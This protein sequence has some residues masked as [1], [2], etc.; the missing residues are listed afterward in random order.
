MT[1]QLN[2][3][4]RKSLW[5]AVAALV[6]AALPT[7]A[8]AQAPDADAVAAIGEE[9]FIYGFPLVMNYKVFHDSFLD[10]QAKGYKGGLNELH[11]EARVYTSDDRAVQTPNSDTPYSLLGADFRAEPLVICVPQVEAGRYYSVQMVDMYTHNYGYL[12]TRATGNDAGCYLVAGPDW[13]GATPAGIKGVF[14][15]ESPFSLIIFRTQL[16]NAGDIGNV[17]RIQAGYKV[18]TLS[19]F[20]NQP[21]PAA[22]PP[23]QWPPAPQEIF[24][25]GFPVA[26]DFLLNFLPPIGPA[27]GEKALRDRFASIGIGPGKTVRPQDLSPE[28]KAAFG[29][30]M[31][32]ALG[33]INHALDHLG[34]EVNGWR[35]GVAAGSREFYNGDYL[36]RAVGTRG[37]IYGNDSAE[38]TYP[39]AKLDQN[40]HPLD[41]GKHAYLMTFAHGELPP[42][43]AFWSITMYDANSQFLVENPIQRYLI[44]TPMLGDLKRNAD[45]SLSIHVQR[46]SPGKDRESNWL[47][48][49]DGPIFMVMRIYW[50]KTEQPSV[51]P[52]GQGAWKPPGI[53]PVGNLKA[54]NAR[55]IGDKSREIAIRTD[56]RYGGDPFFHGPRGYPY[57]NYLEYPKPIQNPNLWPDTQSTYFLSR[58]QMPPGSSLTF[59]GEFPRAIL[60]IRALP[61]GGKHL[62]QHR[63]GSD[64]EANQAGRGFDE[65]LRR[66][67]SAPW[68]SSRLHGAP[69]RGRRTHRCREARTEHTP[70]GQGRR[71][72]A[73][74]PPHL[75]AGSG[76]GR[77]GLGPRGSTVARPWTSHLRRRVG[78]RHEAGCGRGDQ[79]L[80]PADEREHQATGQ[81][82]AV[83]RHR[84]REGQRP[85]ARPGVVTRAPG[86]QVG[87]VLDVALLDPR[88][89]Q[90]A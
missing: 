22:A 41:G 75:H 44:N 29:N 79:A 80:R 30:G 90:D 46:D 14:R 31:K 64:G 56:D 6:I 55:R 74:G 50:P 89:I 28:R 11:N 77:R 67:Q 54:Q 63:R 49:P 18:Q 38:A 17:R 33:K 65:P 82:R 72:V 34:T 78:G 23:I 1:T 86:R 76:P 19:A 5:T 3:C 61:G 52:P 20:L 51:L 68:R 15:C 27:A 62:R 57:W 81:R 2:N 58:F 88:R 42:A 87:E 85:D 47:P 21:A 84:Q 4:I 36:L 35:I 73:D 45:G 25:T 16:F 26:L 71:R 24:T 12:G 53:V 8:P 10:P 32:A 48:A 39:F 37:G 60:Q 66:G 59:K 69:S 70:R 43:N 83:G 40:G 9:A 7:P 13:R